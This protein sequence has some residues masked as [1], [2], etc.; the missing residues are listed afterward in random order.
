M[1]DSCIEYRQLKMV[2]DSEG[3]LFSGLKQQAKEAEDHRDSTRSTSDRSSSNGSE[4][5]DSQ[6]NGELS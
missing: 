1:F 3:S 4:F 2:R 5:S 6:E